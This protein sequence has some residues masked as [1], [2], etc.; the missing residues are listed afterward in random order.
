[1][2][3]AGIVMMY[4]SEDAETAVA[5]TAV[6]AGTYAVGEFRTSRDITILD[7]AE[8]PPVT[9]LFAE[10]PDSLEYDPRKISLFLHRVSRDMSRPIARDDRIHI[11][12]VP[13]QVVTEYVRTA[14]IADGT[15]ID[16]IRYRSSRKHDGFS[17]VLFADEGNV[18]GAWTKD[19]P[20]LKSDE[21]LQ[22]SG[23]VTEQSVELEA[24]VPEIESSTG[25]DE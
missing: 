7:L 2:S 5:E 24:L 1:M 3:P 13:T 8:L 12:Y 21:W 17:L 6:A 23:P 9:G 22:L 15:K 10:L 16:G 19:Y 4:V 11:E 25:E 18:A 20:K 14:G